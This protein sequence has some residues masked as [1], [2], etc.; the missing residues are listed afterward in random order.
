MRIALLH[1]RIRVEEKQLVAALTRQGADVDLIDVR[2]VQLNLADPRAFQQ[3]EAALCRCVSHSQSIALLQV[4]EA[5]GIPCVNSHDV[6]ARCGDKLATSLA[7][8]D[9]GLPTPAVRLAV[10]AE[11]A[12]AAMEEMG[13]PVVVKP[14][15]GSWG[16]LLARINDRA[17]AEAILEHKA[18]LGGPQHG[19]FYIQEYVDKPGRD[20]RTFVIGDRVVA[21]IARHADHWITNT[22]RG[23]TASALTITP[24]IDWLSKEAARAVGGGAVAVDLIERANGEPLINEVNA[25]ME[26]R[27]SSA[28]TGVDIAAELA[29]FLLWVAEYRPLRVD[30]RYV[31]ENA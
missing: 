18:L 13:Y 15:V 23:A 25:T 26:F 31:L 27:N 21:G 22:A 14:T 19:I 17:A 3:Y 20:L 7:L 12:L 8:V 30:G 10:S 11:A 1:S 4:L 16:R 2:T 29:A 9:A 28:P 6:V 5:W 24:E